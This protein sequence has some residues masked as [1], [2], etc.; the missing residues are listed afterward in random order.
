MPFMESTSWNATQSGFMMNTMGLGP[1]IFII[2]ILVAVLGFAII[3]TSLERFTW[4]MKLVDKAVNSVRYTVYG[5]GMSGVVFVLYL[6][7]ETLRTATRGFD[8][9]WYLYA[10]AAYAGFTIIGWVGAK[11]AGRV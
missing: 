6:T 2:L 9:I 7:F 5:I 10:V 4:F 11:V 1:V 8:P 3:I